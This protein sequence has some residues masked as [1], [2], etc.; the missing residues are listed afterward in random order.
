MNR[1]EALT[2]LAAMPVVGGTI[3]TVEK[4][5]LPLFAVLEVENH[6]SDEARTCLVR[7]FQEAFTGPPP[8][9]IVVLD[10]GMKIK[11]ATKE[12]IVE[13]QSPPESKGLV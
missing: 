12:Q 13:A 8:F 2:A 3:R 9:P 11:L 1:R 10:G 6:L 7:A 4:E 5:P